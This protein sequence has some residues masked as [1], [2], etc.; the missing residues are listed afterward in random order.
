MT[1]FRDLGSASDSED[2]P[3]HNNLFTGGEK[4]SLEVEDPGKKDKNRLLVDDIMR[5]AAEQ[6]DQPDD[7]PSARQ[8]TP[9]NR[10][11]TGFGN[12]LGDGTEPEV[13]DDAETV[14]GDDPDHPV[15]AKVTR[16]I[17]FWKQGFL[18]G[19]GPLL[20]YDD[21]A[22]SV[23]LRELNRGRVPM[24]ILNVEFGQDVDVLV[25]RKVDEDWVPPKRAPGGFHGGG[26]R[27]GSP[28]PGEAPEPVHVSEDDEM[29]SPIDLPDPNEEGDCA[30]QF[31]FAN[32]TRVLHRF[33]GTDPVSTVYD[34]VRLHP[35]N[36]SGRAFLLNLVFP[37]EP[38]PDSLDITVEDAGLR[39]SVLIQMW[40]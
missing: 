23:V 33:V 12:K 24:N 11:F 7:R 21:P 30:I 31:R 35:D 8:P 14:I 32:G 22:H 16:E 9:I 3:T 36:E 4:S 10:F 6:L 40:S 13:R 34:F 17:T 39:T 20:R 1:T 27:L 29:Y 25:F 5:K 28:V 19:D 15:P 37:I 2:D 18:V 38:I 26:K